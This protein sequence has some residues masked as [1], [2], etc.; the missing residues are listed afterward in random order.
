MNSILAKNY[1]DCGR[2]NTNTAIFPH[3]IT[4]A[5]T[6]GKHTTPSIFHSFRS[7]PKG[8]GYLSHT[9]LDFFQRFV[10]FLHKTWQAL[11]SAMH[12]LYLL[13]WIIWATILTQTWYADV[14]SLKKKRRG[15]LECRKQYKAVYQRVLSLKLWNHPPFVSSETNVKGKRSHLF[16]FF[17]A[18]QSGTEDWTGNYWQISV[19]KKSCG[20]S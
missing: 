15:Q 6:L 4:S 18:K 12:T 16:A 7:P 9:S 19:L 8:P 3:I 17:T 11:A 5:V 2:S 1:R 10:L 14:H 13:Y 20:K